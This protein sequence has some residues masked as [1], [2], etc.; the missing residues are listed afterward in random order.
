[1]T[2]AEN[3]FC[4]I[5]R[6]REDL[7]NSRDRDSICLFLRDEAVKNILLSLLRQLKSPILDCEVAWTHCD[8][9]TQQRQVLASNGGRSTAS[10]FSLIQI[11][12][13][14]T[15]NLPSPFA[16]KSLRLIRRY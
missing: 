2:V 6:R 12:S 11:S 7:G 14:Y 13:P 3:N 8:V 4:A 10:S 5:A 16:L 15:I 1:M 9:A